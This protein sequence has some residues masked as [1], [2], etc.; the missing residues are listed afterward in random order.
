MAELK[1]GT[2]V[3]LKSG[4][5]QMTVKARLANGYYMCSWFVGT[6]LFEGQF[7][8]DQLTEQDPYSGSSPKMKVAL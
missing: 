5:P 1:A 3:Y 8:A 2:L 4:G 7:A 6:K